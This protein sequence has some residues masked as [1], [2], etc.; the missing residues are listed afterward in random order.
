MSFLISLPLLLLYLKYFSMI[1]LKKLV[2]NPLYIK[3][4]FNPDVELDL[5]WDE[6][7]KNHPEEAPFLLELK[8]KLRNIRLVSE[9]L[10]DEQKIKMAFEISKKLDREDEKAKTRVRLINMLKYVAVAI[11][12]FSLGAILFYTKPKH[13]NL[14]EFISL[15]K[16]SPP[17]DSPMLILPEGKSIAINKG[18]STLN[19]SIAGEIILNEESV[20]QNPVISGI[21]QL[22]MPYGSSSKI[23]LTDGSTVWLNAGSRLLYPSNFTGKTRE[24]VLFGEA[25]FKVASNIEKPFIVKTSELEIKALGTEFNVSA[26]PEDKIIQTV[27]KSGSVSIKITVSGK[28]E[29]EILLFPNQLASFNKETKQSV[30]SNVNTDFY[31]LWTNGLLC[32]E[33]QD[34][35]RVIKSLERFYNIKIQFEEPLTGGI[36]ISGKLDLNRAQEE[37][38]EYVSKVSDT[39]FERVGDKYFKIK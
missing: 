21:C 16:S 6:Y 20:V 26:Y 18:G 12:F 32:F 5:Y 30:I 27:L 13:E 33:N 28:N 9:N 19:H 24:V 17:V 22:V 10:S 15:M 36:K 7:L 1:D 25:Y 3:W 31:T 11:L 35:N 8:L 39:K 23:V 29:Q 34:L 2:E 37:V 38:F 4:I 14:D